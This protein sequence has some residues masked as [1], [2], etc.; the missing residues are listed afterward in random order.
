MGSTD[1]CDIETA[2]RSE[3]RACEVPGAVTVLLMDHRTGDC[4][5]ACWVGGPCRFTSRPM[6]W[7][8]RQK[9]R[10]KLVRQASNSDTGE[11]P[12]GQRISAQRHHLLPGPAA[13]LFVCSENLT[14]FFESI[15]GATPVSR[16]FAA[17]L[18]TT[19]IVQFCFV[20]VMLK[21]L[22]AQDTASPD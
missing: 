20:S 22:I 5:I 6:P 18:A 17:N 10:A 2:Q 3:A 8:Q 14:R 13:M 4:R 15:G 1:I 21:R 11:M 19:E 16:S 9:N 7:Q 12:G